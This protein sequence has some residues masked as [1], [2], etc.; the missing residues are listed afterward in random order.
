M[1]TPETTAIVQVTLARPVW[2]PEAVAL[3]DDVECARLTRLRRPID[4]D[5]YL[6][7]HALTRVVLG[8]LLHRDPGALRF[9]RDCATCA[10][11]HGKPRLAHDD[12]P[13]F[14]FSITG[15]TWRQGA[16]TQGLVGVAVVTSVVTDARNTPDTRP[17]IGLDLEFLGATTFD[18]FDEVALHDVERADLD[19]MAP[20]ARPRARAIWWAR[21]EAVVKALGTGLRTEP[22]TIATTPPAAG[23]VLAAADAP[24]LLEPHRWPPLA[25]VDLSSAHL[26]ECVVGAVCV[27]GVD[28]V[29][30]TVA[31][32]DPARDVISWT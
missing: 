5:A 13:S 1:T 2:I 19:A 17:D 3:L 6:T 26:T 23:D 31:L 15:A 29:R 18:G 30:V 16:E 32:A 8:R 24:R 20:A 14:P 10:E 22:A 28:E 27:L 11:P 25:V 12:V 21:K 4:R 7:R 9:T